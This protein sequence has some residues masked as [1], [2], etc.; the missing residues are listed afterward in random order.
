MTYSAFPLRPPR[1][2]RAVT[3]ARPEAGIHRAYL[4]YVWLDEPALTGLG[5][6]PPALDTVLLS[7]KLANLTGKRYSNVA[8]KRR[9]N[10]DRGN[11]PGIG[12]ATQR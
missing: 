6:L 8:A 7:G 2:R 5:R 9:Y 3:A 10:I 4:C 1:T 12:T 11:A